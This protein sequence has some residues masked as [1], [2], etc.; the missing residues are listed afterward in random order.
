MP[1]DQ[2]RYLNGELT[3]SE[4]E[5]L[6]YVQQGEY[7]TREVRKNFPELAN[8]GA[9]GTRPCW[10]CAKAALF[11]SGGYISDEEIREVYTR[12]KELRAKREARKLERASK[13]LSR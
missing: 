10:H 1:V 11:E 12:W 3:L 13:R 4:W 6:S 2:R 9:S 7:L 5:Q 8:W